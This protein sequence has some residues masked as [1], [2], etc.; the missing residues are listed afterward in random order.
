[1][2]FIDLFAGI[3][4][5]HHALKKYG[6]KCVLVCEIDQYCELIY[7]HSFKEE[8]YQ[9]ISN[10]RE[11][12]RN[13]IKDLD[14]IKTKEQLN[15][16]V[17]RHDILCAGFPCQPFSKSGF[18]RGIKDA[19]RG[20]LFFDILQIIEAKKPK[21]II[22]ENVRNLAGPR[23]FHT[24]NIII[25]NLINLGYE[26]NQTPLIFSPH[27]LP[28]D[29]GGA[30]QNRERVFIVG[31]KK[32]IAKNKII[33]LMKFNTEL[34]EKKFFN[35][36][37][38]NIN[39]IVIEEK[40]IKNLKKY[41]VSKEEEMYL[42][43]WD[44]FV[45]NLEEENI[46]GF[47]II[48]DFWKTNPEINFQMY[49]W[50]KTFRI[51]NSIFYNKNSIFC[52]KF[53]AKDWK[54]KSIIEFPRSRRI[55]EWQA[56]KQ[57]NKKSGRTLK[58]LIIQLRPSGIRVKPATYFPALVAITQT[59]IIGPLLRNGATNYRRLTP[60]ECARLQG[61]P[62]YVYDNNLINDNQKYKQIGNG[63]N[64][65]IVEKIIEILLENYSA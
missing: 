29:M 47:P 55:L 52:D 64:V 57:H 30:P 21:Y 26:V 60:I 37:N 19:T 17:P 36:D 12:T 18:Q 50:E 27:L 3:G 7:K 22:L 62:D 23:H 15:E 11:L 25:N 13:D 20:T 40:N 5:F 53:L 45:K 46:P 6:A 34:R 4:G 1:M 9:F 54:G 35:P 16:I 39:N 59:S 44:F 58:D 2:E 49:E 31:I 10:I 14:S 63:V 24:Y 33:K 42:N 32:N 56:N 43:A 41:Q 65:G 51:K 48:V 61:I 28:A 8:G 38:W